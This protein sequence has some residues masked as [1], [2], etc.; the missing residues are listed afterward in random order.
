MTGR[1]TSHIAVAIVPLTDRSASSLGGLPIGFCSK[2]LAIRKSVGTSQTARYSWF[3]QRSGLGQ[4]VCHTLLEDRRVWAQSSVRDVLSH[5]SDTWPSARIVPSSVVR[6]RSCCLLFPISVTVHKT[7]RPGQ[8]G[9]APDCACR[10]TVLDSPS[11]MLFISITAQKS[12]SCA[13][14]YDTI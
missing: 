9:H 14:L 6:R 4:P 8:Y 12:G 10:V 7:G 2:S 1:F 13:T 5:F 3:N 11:R